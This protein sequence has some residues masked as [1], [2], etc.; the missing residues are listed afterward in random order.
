MF[1]TLFNYPVDVNGVPV[2][3]VEGL[4]RIAR[5]SD[6]YLMVCCSTADDYSA[7]FD[8]LVSIRRRITFWVD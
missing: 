1:G 3:T 7:A 8:A 6:E 5:S 4:R 2:R